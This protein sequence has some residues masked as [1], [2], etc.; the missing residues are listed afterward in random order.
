MLP[1]CIKERM[2]TMILLVASNIFMTFACYAPIHERI[3]VNF[4][5]L[6]IV[7]DS[8]RSQG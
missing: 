4:D 7:P 2:W 5:G 6:L 3:I 8:S 1:E